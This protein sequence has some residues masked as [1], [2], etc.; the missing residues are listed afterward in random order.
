M[1]SYAYDYLNDSLILD[2]SL[3]TRFYEGIPDSVLERELIRYRE[4]CLRSLPTLNNE[5]QHIITSSRCL[6]TDK[7]STVK[8]LKQAALYLEE[9]VVTDPIFKLT[10]FR[11]E[12]T[13]VY[14]AFMGM[15]ATPKIDREK[16]ASAA[17]RI[18]ELRPF[19]TGGYVKIYPV[20]YELENAKEIPLFYSE[21]GFEDC[22]ST[23]VLDK[24][25]A[26]AKVRT[27][28]NVEGQMY[29]MN[30]LDLCRNISIDFKGMRG[31]FGMGYILNP[32][33]FEPTNNAQVYTMIQKMVT[34]PPTQEVFDRW[35][36]Q[37]IN[38]TAINHYVELSKRVA[39]CDSLGC[40]F[41]TEHS[42][43]S[44]L[45]DMNAGQPSII[46]NTLNCTLQMEVPFLDKVSSA[47]LMSIRNDDG[48]SFNSF[49]VE[50]EKGLRQARNESDPSRIRNIIEDT[51]HELFEVQTSKITPQVKN[52]KKMHSL[53]LSIIT[54][55]L[56]LSVVTNGFSL[57]ATML[58]AAHGYKSYTDYR[59]KITSNPCHF[60]WRV[61]QEMK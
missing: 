1:S 51:Q 15:A 32:T 49:R 26:A 46:E 24:Y 44:D 16:L 59:S 10:D 27:V 9:A 6:A 34:E 37:S 17:I 22:L 53:D 18:I 7:M 48:D 56:G 41:G 13:E 50:L 58:A 52:L 8:T 43:E 11:S 2:G 36:S 54:A 23:V 21:V 31:G 35:V 30:Y 19:V 40:M 3:I 47:D 4:H 33:E 12:T 14:S 45:L 25:K 57:L 38:R 55:G 29:I 39:L 42:F 5:L 28:K 60:L 20:S 61:K